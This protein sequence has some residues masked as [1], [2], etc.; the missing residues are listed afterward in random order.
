MSS[1][2]FRIHNEELELLSQRA[3]FWQAQQSLIVSD[4][5]LGKAGHFRKHGIP[6]SRKVHLKDL[7]I[8]ETLIRTKC[9]Q[10][11][12]LLGDLFH[13]Y[14]ND[15]WNDF[16][17]FLEVHDQIKFTLVEGNHDILT[18]YPKQ[19]MLTTKLNCGPF[20]FT[21]IQQADDLYNISGHIHP[22]VL[23]RGKARQ[24]MVMSC[25][26][27]GEEFA[28]MPAFGQFTGVKKIKPKKTDRVFAIAEDN[29]I[30]LI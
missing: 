13:S 18:N 17:K 9:P 11:V 27:F 23:I 15:E 29:V 19:L 5:H 16:L 1:C 3:L 24:G 12:I 25:F 22:G 28:I 26:L 2:I 21:H 20:S 7:K 4:L 10:H 14:E 30:E 8:L 6:V